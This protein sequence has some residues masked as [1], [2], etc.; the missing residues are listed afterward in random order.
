MILFRFN[1]IA[2]PST[3]RYRIIAKRLQ[4]GMPFRISFT[5]GL[6]D[7]FSQRNSGI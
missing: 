2:S 5:G 3:Q 4:A 1:S 6:N 7:T